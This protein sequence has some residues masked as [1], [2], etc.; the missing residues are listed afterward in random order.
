MRGAIE[1]AALV[2]DKRWRVGSKPKATSSISSLQISDPL[3]ISPS[4]PAHSA[5]PLQKVHGPGFCD[6]HKTLASAERAAKKLFS[7]DHDAN[8]H[9][10]CKLQDASFI[11]LMLQLT[12]RITFFENCASCLGGEHNFAKR[13]HASSIENF[14]FLTPNGLDKSIF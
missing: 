7:T 11:I 5:R 6:F 10:K 8:L 12:F 9:Q 4:G 14:T 2:V 1:S 13:F 3:K